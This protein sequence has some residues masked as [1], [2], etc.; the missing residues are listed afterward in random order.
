[1]TLAIS[2]AT[3]RDSTSTIRSSATNN[4]IPLQTT[5]R[6]VAQFSRAVD[7]DLPVKL[8][9]TGVT[10]D[11]ARRRPHATTGQIDLGRSFRTVLGPLASTLRQGGTDDPL[12]GSATRSRCPGSR[13]T[14]FPGTPSSTECEVI[15]AMAGGFGQVACDGHRSFDELVRAGA[16]RSP[17]LDALRTR[18]TPS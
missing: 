2:A 8:S 10:P 11:P 5:L 1:L 4:G 3:A 15:R 14:S 9:V 12:T 6:A 7:G 13:A 18:P 17:G 16:M